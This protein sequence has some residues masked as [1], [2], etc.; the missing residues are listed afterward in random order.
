MKKYLLLAVISLAVANNSVAEDQCVSIDIPKFN[1]IPDLDCV[2]SSDDLILSKLSDQVFLYDLIENPDP[3]EPTC[4]TIVNSV[5][6]QN[7]EVAGTIQNLAGDEMNITFSGVAGLTQNTY[8]PFS[9]GSSLSFTAATLVTISTTDR[10][11]LGQL[12]TRDAGTIFFNP[13]TEIEGLP[14]ISNDIAAARLSVSRGT[15]VFKKTSGYID[16]NGKE[17]NPFEE[18]SASGILCGKNLADDLFGIE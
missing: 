16:E 11:T 18:A 15:G 4:F 13:P 2:I 14:P 5:L 7:P 12:A 10:N 8:N 6:E 17:F 9:N 3:D 1:L